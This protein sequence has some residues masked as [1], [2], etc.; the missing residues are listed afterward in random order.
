MSEKVY[1]FDT[2][3]RDGEQSPGCAMDAK[4]KLMIARQLD[5]LGIEIIEAGFA[6]SSPDEQRAIQMIAEEVRRP[7]ICSLS[8]TI[9]EDIEA[10]AQAVEKAAHPRIH[11]F[12]AT[13]VIHMEKKLRKSPEEILEMIDREVRRAKRY[14]DNVEFSPEDAARS[15]KKF[16][17]QAIAVAIKAGAT[18]INIPDTVGYSV[19]REFY[20]LICY[21][22][23]NLPDIEKVT[24]S[25]HC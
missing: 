15:G 22:K 4:S 6:I 12:V 13:S 24:I 1:I 23:Q 14:V 5:R 11:T 21:L 3:L 16:L 17:T 20:N 2:T 25:A 7:I 9:K 8:R 10:S 19:G 18:V